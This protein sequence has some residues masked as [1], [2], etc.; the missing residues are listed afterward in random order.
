[1]P[2]KIPSLAK[3][4]DSRGTQGGEILVMKC[5]CLMG[6]LVV[7][8]AGA[9]GCGGKP[10]DEG[11]ASQSSGG[12]A[13]AVFTFLEAVRQGNDEQAGGMLT[14]LAQEKTA[15][16]NMVV[17]PPGSDTASFEVGEVENVSDDSV[18]VASV[19]TDV[20]HEG[21]HRTDEI[22][23]ILKR[24]SSGWRIAGMATKIFP[25]QEPVALNFENPQEM[26]DK[27]Q[28]AEEEARR[29]AGSQSLEARKSE[30]P[31]QSERR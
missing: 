26:L 10:A 6:L 28:L 13:E 9:V 1:M 27:Q 16:M 24:E 2:R 19:W 15:E 8:L 21:N 3:G 12:P 7:A 31:F 4:R 30:D 22:T 14:Q 25:D 17:A 11:S 29:R 23:W 18:H 5:N 20:D